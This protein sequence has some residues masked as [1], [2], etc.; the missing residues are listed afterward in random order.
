M[1]PVLRGSGLQ[2]PCRFATRGPGAVHSAPPRA[3]LTTLL[4]LAP[5]LPASPPSPQLHTTHTHSSP[6]TPQ[7]RAHSC[8]RRRQ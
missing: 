4:L 6:Y 5:S 3:A 1:A 7:W 8:N 2:V